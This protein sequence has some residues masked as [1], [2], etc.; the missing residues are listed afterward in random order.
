MFSPKSTTAIAWLLLCLLQ[1][2][3]NT[4]RVVF[5]TNSNLLLR[6]L[7][8]LRNDA[9]DR[10]HRRCRRCVYVLRPLLAP[11]IWNVNSHCVRTKSP[12]R[13]TTTHHTSRYTS[14]YVHIKL[15]FY[16]FCW[17]NA[18]VLATGCAIGRF[19]VWESET[20][21]TEMTENRVEREWERTQSSPPI[22][23][24]KAMVFLGVCHLAF[25]ILW[26]LLIYLNLYFLW[27]LPAV[28][29][30]IF[31]PTFVL[32]FCCSIHRLRLFTFS[33]W[34]AW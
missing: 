29:Y 16:C 2:R 4:S 3:S 10:R 8:T 34:S 14:I 33:Y 23:G 12:Q 24:Q 5:E 13:F 28:V 15:N 25:T 22:A 9:V 11:E 6:S 27:F 20:T 7:C 17:T 18:F 30:P 1:R 21:T 26:V 31:F 32:C 19:R